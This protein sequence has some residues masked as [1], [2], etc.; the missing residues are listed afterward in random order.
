LFV[1]ERGIASAMHD[2]TR[3]LQRITQFTPLAD[4]LARMAARVR[5]VA[6]RRLEPAA[7]LG[8]I[9]AEDINLKARLPAATIALRDG[10][11]VQSEL[12]TDASPYAPT[13][14]PAASWVEVGDEVGRGHDAVL[15]PEAVTARTEPVAAVTPTFPGDGILPAGG[16]VPAG[17]RIL[18][19][20]C[21]ISRLHVALLQVSGLEGVP[22][23]S[24]RL[25]LALARPDPDWIVDTIV[26]CIAGAV[27]A[28]GSVPTN[29]NSEIDFEHALAD[30]TSDA[31]V[32]IGGSGCGQ[33]D[34]AVRALAATGDL[35][36][37][38]I[39]LIPG[40]TAAFGMIGARPVL[41]LP[42]RLD[43]ALAAWHMLGRAMLQKLT[44]STEALLTARAKLSQK[45]SSPGG[46]AELVP[47]QCDGPT[48][49][50]L[51]GTYLPVAMLAQANGW[52]FIEPE[53]EGYAAGSD[54]AIR[55][56]P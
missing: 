36:V 6:A 33:R 28:G 43:A 18:H 46:L 1:K 25:R 16:D 7:A 13:S 50:P 27:H 21:R 3:G 11:A 39:G 41:V 17:A 37:H 52:I 54:V 35:V 8:H 29:P 5:P 10:W 49:T 14:I 48:A 2:Q 4:A 56:W 24:P 30:T 47:V 20:G 19:C 23:R 42:G 26:A 15:P 34:R 53:S 31:V 44:G 12:T 45:L 38:G 9:L 55:P 22:V 51:A 32:V 40:E